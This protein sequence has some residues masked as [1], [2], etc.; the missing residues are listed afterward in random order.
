MTKKFL[1]AAMALTLAASLPFEAA[2]A[3]GGGGGF[4]GGGGGGS[5]GGD[6]GS[7]DHG[8]SDHG[9]FSFN[10]PRNTSQQRLYDQARR[11]C[12]GPRYPSGASPQINYSA[13]S[14]SCFEPGNIRH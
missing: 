5:F 10:P 12:N 1:I 7:A 14:F 13:N 3:R 4:G 2:L 8:A 9:G 11:E 6:H